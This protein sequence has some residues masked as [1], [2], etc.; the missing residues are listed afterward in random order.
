MM[1]GIAAAELSHK[2]AAGTATGFIGWF[3][4]GG[5][6]L[7]GGPFGLLIQKYGWDGYFIA[8]ICCAIIAFSTFAP[9]GN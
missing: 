2:N 3:A 4:Y 1:I 5:A 8:L 9:L 6:A 7:A